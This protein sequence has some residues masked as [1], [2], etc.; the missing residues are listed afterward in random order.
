MNESE[1]R[2]WFETVLLLPAVTKTKQDT[3]TTTTTNNNNNKN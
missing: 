3:T 2:S 1:F